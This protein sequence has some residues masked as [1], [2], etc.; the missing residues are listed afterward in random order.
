MVVHQAEAAVVELELHDVLDTLEEEEGVD[1]VWTGNPVTFPWM[2][3]L[4]EEAEAGVELEGEEVF[5]S[6]RSHPL[7]YTGAEALHNRE[8]V[9]SVEDTHRLVV[10]TDC[11]RRDS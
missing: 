4:R 8:A 10:H 3:E 6:A 7:A 11:F 2:Q 1:V 9:P 5:P